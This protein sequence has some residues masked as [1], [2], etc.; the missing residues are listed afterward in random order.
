MNTSLNQTVP[1]SSHTPEI[2]ESNY[3]L[4]APAIYPNRSC[5]QYF[6]L[7]SFFKNGSSKL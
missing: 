3:I 4:H 5:A 2:P 1:S 7:Y 6:I